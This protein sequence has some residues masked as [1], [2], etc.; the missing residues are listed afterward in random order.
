[1]DRGLLSVSVKALPSKANNQPRSP[2]MCQSLLQKG[3]PL[4]VAHII[5]RAQYQSGE[6]TAT[7][8]LDDLASDECCQI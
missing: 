7:I 6:P 1:M 8:D 4:L 2:K 3:V 5:A